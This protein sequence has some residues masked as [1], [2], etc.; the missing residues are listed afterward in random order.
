VGATVTAVPMV[1]GTSPGVMTPV[2]PEKTPVS[3][4]LPPAAM[5]AGLAV[6]LL[7]AGGTTA[8]TVTV[9]V[10]VTAVPPVGVTV[11][12]YVV[13]AA[14]LTA[15]GVPLVAG[16]LPGVILPVP[17]VKTPVRVVLVPSVMVA[18]AAVKL[19]M[20]ATGTT[21][22]ELEEPPQPA[23]PAKDTPASAAYK[24]TTK[25]LFMRISSANDLWIFL[26]AHDT[27][28]PRWSVYPFHRTL[29]R[30]ATGAL[31]GRLLCGRASGVY[32]TAGAVCPIAGGGL[33]F[34]GCVKRCRLP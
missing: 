4:E 31:A 7:I 27:A 25:N 22:V 5:V 32:C 6:K 16:K 3:M 20:L 12:V 13:V 11:S 21:G 18:E 34:H 33:F 30:N 1:A 14:G 28:W 15:T 8:F 9:T 26:P 17:P 24:A 29:V 19:V 2:P 10:W 23:R